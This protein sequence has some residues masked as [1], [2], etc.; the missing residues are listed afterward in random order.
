M[1]VRVVLAD[2]QV[3]F[4]SA[5]RALLARTGACEVLSEASD[6]Q[7][8][9][10]YIQRDAPDLVLTELCLPLI[11]G[12]E[13]IRKSKQSGSR[14]SFLVLS[15]QV[16]RRQVENALQAGASGFVSKDDPAEDLLSAIEEVGQGGT[17]FST[18]ITRHLV[19][20][21]LGRSHPASIHPSLSSREVEI[22]QQIAEGLSSK[23]IGEVLHVSIR[24][25]DSHRANIMEKLGMH[26]VANLVRYAIRE[27]L[28]KP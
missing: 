18:T 10:A 24:T 1:G 14:A 25:V 2:S 7:Q 8:A 20:I 5:V 15:N 27:G 9:L 21:A 3:L 22:V 13:V 19:D 28:I 6:G 12:A 4:R 23:E 16:G 11:D 17:Y 26:K